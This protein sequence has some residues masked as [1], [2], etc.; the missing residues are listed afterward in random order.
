MRDGRP[1]A[2][3]RLAKVGT[4]WAT[5]VQRTSK[6]VQRVRRRFGKVTQNATLLFKARR[7]TPLSFSKGMPATS[8]IPPTSERRFAR[9]EGEPQRILFV[10]DD[11]LI[12][13][14][15]DRVLRR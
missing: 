12:L 10:D 8:Q 2:A 3:A 1:T 7:K 14:S 6:P 9:R 4:T 5:Y 13:R 15:I 11:E